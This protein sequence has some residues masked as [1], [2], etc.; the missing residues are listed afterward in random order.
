M[1]LRPHARARR[2]FSTSSASPLR[3]ARSLAAASF[4]SLA[5]TSR[6]YAGC[7]PASREPAREPPPRRALSQEPARASPRREP[8]RER[9]EQIE[10]LAVVH[11]RIAGVGVYPGS[12]PPRARGE[13]LP[14]EFERGVFAPAFPCPSPTAIGAS[15]REP[16]PQTRRGLRDLREHG[17]RASAVV[18]ANST[19]AHAVSLS[20]SREAAA[21][22]AYDSAAS[23][24][25]GF[26]S[27]PSAASVAKARALF[28]AQD[29]CDLAR[30]LV[31]TRFD[32]AAH[33]AGSR[34]PVYFERRGNLRRLGESSGSAR[35]RSPA[36]KEASAE[37]AQ[38]ERLVP[39]FL[40]SARRGRR[41]RERFLDGRGVARARVQARRT[42]EQLHL[43][44]VVHLEVE[45]DRLR[46]REFRGL[47]GAPRLDESREHAL[48]RHA[49]QRQSV[50][51]QR[52]CGRG[53]G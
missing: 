15:A 52:S 27:G 24:S 7:L 19:S 6:A 4:A 3:P 17:G 2:G 36:P 37:L 18:G 20:L 32:V 10:L 23:K 31:Q 40:D 29:A 44:L 13:R 45:R 34:I 22:T 51:S 43:R 30:P 42:R 39:F 48:D 33:D 53:G 14:P 41:V 8:A 5:V 50:E 26:D 47:V 35:S 49:V 16:V 38:R 1:L 46:E 11:S 9:E 21:E 25:A 28:L 12:V